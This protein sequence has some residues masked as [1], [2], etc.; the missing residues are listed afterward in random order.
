MELL[1]KTQIVFIK[2]SDVINTIP[3]HGQA[4]YPHAKGK[5]RIPLRINPAGTKYSGMNHSTTKYFQPARSLAHGAMP[6]ATQ[7]AKA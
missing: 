6:A 4:F 3:E 5:T 2:M 1:Q 7:T